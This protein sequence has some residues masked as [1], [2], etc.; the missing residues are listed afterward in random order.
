MHR[1][2]LLSNGA[3]EEGRIELRRYLGDRP[4]DVT[5]DTDIVEWWSVCVF[6]SFHFVAVLMCS[7]RLIISCTLL[8]PALR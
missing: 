3:H 6:D 4:S 1:L 5:R 7:Y 8:W 2:T